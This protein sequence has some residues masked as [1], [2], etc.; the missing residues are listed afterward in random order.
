M[1]T[2]TNHDDGVRARESG[3]AADRPR[4]GWTGHRRDSR[5]EGLALALSGAVSVAA[6]LG[7]LGAWKTMHAL[8]YRLTPRPG[9]GR[10]VNALFAGKPAGPMLDFY[11]VE[12]GKELFVA[13]CSACHG[14]DAHGLKGLGKDLTISTFVAGLTD[15]EMI[16]FVNRGRDIGSPLNTTKV[17]MPPKGGNPALNDEKIADIVAFIRGLQDPRRVPAA[18]P[19][20]AATDVAAGTPDK[21]AE[22]SGMSVDDIIRQ[23]AAAGAPGGSVEDVIR[24]A[25]AAEAAPQAEEEEDPAEVVE[26]GRGVFVSMCVAC[27]GTDAKGL[28]NQGPDLIASQFVATGSAAEL[29]S[30]LKHGRPAADKWNTKKKDT[31]A[32][33]DNPALNEQKIADTVAYLRGL[34]TEAKK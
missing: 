4:E 9:E 7:T 8:Q 16:A 13:N 23:A 27:H 20:E 21:P 10:V 29:V 24:Q 3:G 22:A 26:R 32:V 5:R 12:S 31:P 1:P 2:F 14:V 17:Q 6:V 28:P 18:P 25:A 30:F 15:P 19:E 11:M 33:C 34:G